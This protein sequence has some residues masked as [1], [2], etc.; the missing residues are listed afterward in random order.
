MNSSKMKKEHKHPSV[1]KV[2]KFNQSRV[3]LET[4][5]AQIH[6]SSLFVLDTDTSIKTVAGLH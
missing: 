3:E 1:V 6:D 2:H 5:N 4:P